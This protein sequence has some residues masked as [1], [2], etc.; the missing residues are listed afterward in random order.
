M[1]FNLRLGVNL[2]FLAGGAFFVYGHAREHLSQP[3]REFLIFGFI[4][5]GGSSF[6]SMVR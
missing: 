4:F 6:S 2:L 1:Y 5:F 3:N